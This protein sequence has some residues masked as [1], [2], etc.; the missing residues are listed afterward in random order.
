MYTF[1]LRSC[2]T[3]KSYVGSLNVNL[4]AL[5]LSALDGLWSMNLDNHAKD[6]GSA[7]VPLQSRLTCCRAHVPLN[8]CHYIEDGVLQCTSCFPWDK[9]LL[10]L[11]VL[12]QARC[13][14]ECKQKQRSP[15]LGSV[16]TIVEEDSMH[17]TL[18]EH[19]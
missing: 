5:V 4:A 14:A 8:A 1:P 7:M 16:V 19:W 3:P 13:I 6:C 12:G 18:R 17:A 2:C 9:H 15:H 11:D 10:H